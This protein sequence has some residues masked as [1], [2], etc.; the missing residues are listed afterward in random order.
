M[1]VESHITERDLTTAVLLRTSI[2]QVYGFDSIR[3]L[4]CKGCNLSRYRQ[5]P[6]K[7]DPTD[8]SL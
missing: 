7:R 1:A 5:L 4:F 6:R 2:L 3:I 8:V